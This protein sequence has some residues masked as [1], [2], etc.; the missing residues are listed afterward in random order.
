MDHLMIVVVGDHP[1]SQAPD[2][3]TGSRDVWLVHHGDPGAWPALAHDGRP[4]LVVGGREHE[5]AVRHHA[6]VAADLGA[7][8]AWL[9][10]DLGPLAQLLTARNTAH[11]AIS[12]GAA[13]LTF[14][15]LAA[16]TWS[17]AWMRSVTRLTRP[18]PSIGQHA[19]SIAPGDGYVV[20]LSP[21][22]TVTSVRRLQRHGFRAGTPE[23]PRGPV[24]RTG[25]VP[26]SVEELLAALTGGAGHF[27]FDRPAEVSR[28]RFGTDEAVEIAIP[29]QRDPTPPV[30]LVTCPSCGV[31]VPA[32]TCPFCR[33]RTPQPDLRGAPA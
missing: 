29:P 20:E 30:A 23:G 4:T 24:V 18:A 27:V 22:T 13:V 2:T 1:T 7:T 28:E 33:V 15:A 17:G 5:R 10:T 32:P 21:R 8:S 9:V 31:A 26:A 25:D 3:Q 14:E 12:A 19:R 11:I 16:T 6:A